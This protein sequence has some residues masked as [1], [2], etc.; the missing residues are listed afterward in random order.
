MTIIDIGK[1]TFRKAVKSDQ[2]LLK[3][4]FNKPH[5]KEFW[6][7]S[8]EMWENVESY[9]N[10]HKVLYDYWIGLFEKE[11]YCL[12]ITSDASENDPSAPGSDNHFLQWIEPQG[13]TWTIDF[14]IGEE[15][16]LGKGLSYLTLSKF[17]ETQEDVSAFLID[18][19]V[20]NVKAIHVYE[21]AGFEKIST[22]T[23]KNGYFFGKEHILMKK[24]V[25]LK[26]LPFR[27]EDLKEYLEMAPKLWPHHSKDELAKEFERILSSHNEIGFICKKDDET[28]GFITMSLKFE[29]VHEAT[30]T[31]V[32]YLEGIFVKEKYRK[33]GIAK[34]MYEAG[35]KWAKSKGCSQMGSDTWDWNKDS[36]LFHGKLGFKVAHPIV[37]FIKDIG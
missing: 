12:I 7:N 18:P 31:P 2:D 34:K 8:A 15:S 35:E 24:R 1:I 22:F 19:E 21:K 11:P 37:H 32:G 10:G 20:S 17:T 16:F 29:H 23:P 5:V 27:K 14:M 13:K 30:S 4:W 28:L 26:I 9:L 33:L 25:D 3:K 6:D 36:V